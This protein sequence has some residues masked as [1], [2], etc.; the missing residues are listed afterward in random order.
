MSRLWKSKIKNMI[1][2]YRNTY[3]QAYLRIRFVDKDDVTSFSNG[4]YFS[5]FFPTGIT[6]VKLFKAIF[7]QISAQQSYGA[8]YCVLDL[9][10]TYEYWITITNK[11]IKW[12][13]LRAFVRENR[14]NHGLCPESLYCRNWQTVVLSLAIW[15]GIF[16]VLMGWHAWWLTEHEV[17]V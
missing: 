14:A 7:Q 4:S 1:W 10:C 2:S 13:L 11:Q 6:A 16:P 15:K 17:L 12:K 9:C 3:L 8:V 5:Y